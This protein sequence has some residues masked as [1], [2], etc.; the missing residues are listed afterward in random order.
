MGMR[1]HHPHN[2]AVLTFR[3]G[4]TTVS[5]S[6]EGANKDDKVHHTAVQMMMYGGFFEQVK[7]K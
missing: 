4:M 1:E 5:V 6:L 7:C 2:A 3:Q